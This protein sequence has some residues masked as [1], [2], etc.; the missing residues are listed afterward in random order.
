MNSSPKDTLAQLVPNKGFVI[1]LSYNDYRF[2]VECKTTS[3][4]FSPP[5]H[6]K[7]FSKVFTKDT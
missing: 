2:K 3:E 6:R 1:Y 7:C 5:F 4:N